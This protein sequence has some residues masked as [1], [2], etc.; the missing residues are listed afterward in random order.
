[1]GFLVVPFFVASL[2]GRFAIVRQLLPA[3]FHMPMWVRHRPRA[4]R[5]LDIMQQERGVDKRRTTLHDGV[6]RWA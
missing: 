5:T 6:R 4:V 1:M 2:A 3:C